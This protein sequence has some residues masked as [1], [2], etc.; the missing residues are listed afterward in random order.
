MVLEDD[1]EIGANATVDR[2]T[3]GATVIGRGTKID[4]LVMVGHGCRIGPGCLLAAQVG[5]AGGTRPRNRASCWA[6]RSGASGHLTHRRRGAGGG[7]VRHP[8]RYPGAARSTAAIPAVEIRG[9]RRVTSSLPRL[10]AR[11]C[12]GCAGWSAPSGWP[13]RRSGL[14][15]SRQDVP[16]PLS[17]QRAEP[18]YSAGPALRR[19]NE[20]RRRPD[21]RGPPDASRTWRT[22]RGPEP[23]ARPRGRRLPGAGWHRRGGDAPPGRPRRL[24]RGDRAR[25]VPRHLCALPG[26]V[27]A[28]RSTPRWPWSSCPRRSWTRRAERC[29]RRTIGLASYDGDEIDLAPLVDEQ[30][31]LALPTRPLCSEDCRGLCP[32]C[33]ANLNAGPCDCPAPA[34]DGRLAVLQTMLRAR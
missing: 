34:A 20:D 28:S 15:T 26:G 17:L 21:S 25:R 6:G 1:V 7:A 33:G 9:W 8:W 29:G 30:T 11:C 19:C 2:A 12:A 5:L 4:N 31:L 14:V 16:A 23:G 13:T 3:L 24:L 22:R 27:L 32:R 10:P 18:L